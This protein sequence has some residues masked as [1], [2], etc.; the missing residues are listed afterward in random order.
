M[1]NLQFGARNA[2]LISSLV[3][4]SATGV[5]EARQSHAPPFLQGER[6]V[7]PP[8]ASTAPAQPIDVLHYGLDLVPEVTLRRIGGTATLLVAVVAPSAPLDSVILDAVKLEVFAVRVNGRDRGWSVPA[9]STTLSIEV[10]SAAPGD[11]LRQDGDLLTVAIDYVTV[12]QRGYRVFSTVAYTF[13][14]PEDARYWF[15]CVDA[16]RDKALFDGRFTVPDGFVVGSNGVLAGVETVPPLPNGA[17]RRWHW[18]ED[19]PIATYLICLQISRY[20]TLHDDADGIPLVYLMYPEDTL[21]ARV[22]FE[23]VPEMVRHFSTLFGPYPFEQYGMAA[24]E[25]FDFGGMEHQTMVTIVRSWVRG[26]RAQELGVA[27]ELSHM[28]F[29]DA[30]SPSQWNDMWLNEGFARYAEAL[31]L[32]H[33]DGIAAR[34]GR[35]S[36]ATVE[37]VSEDLMRR[38]PISNPPPEYLFGRTIYDK[39]AWVLHMLRREV[40]DERFFEILREHQERRRYGNSSI[41][42]F[43]ALAEEVSG[44][45]LDAFFDQWLDGVGYPILEYAA[46]SVP[47]DIAAGGGS[48]LLSVEMRQV[49]GT[50]GIPLLDV[51]VEIGVRTPSGERRFTV[52]SNQAMQTFEFALDEPALDVL[53]D[54]DGWLLKQVRRRSDLASAE[55]STAS[56]E[57]MYPNPAR[58]QASLELRIPY[59]GPLGTISGYADPTPVRVDVFDLRGRRV[60]T[61]LDDAL[62]PG[63]Y[64]VPFDGRDS[65]G[66][67]LAG[68]VYLIRVATPSGVETK[69]L[70]FVP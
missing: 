27:H 19:D 9:D 50:I 24:V 65:G 53:L 15:P 40:G 21:K 28:W 32:E 58:A 39:G 35:M 66:A 3:F 47:V 60:R 26:D 42:D 61:L 69:R 25:P 34:D 51:P 16:P 57:N 2:I 23:R 54:P 14:E 17:T 38:Y 6:K 59:T 45:P 12:P 63:R 43:R 4:A 68:G 49:Q 10:G 36:R 18:S 56:V 20:A 31:W 37:Y 7:A 29:G 41:A 5:A 70:A 8:A 30:V 33:V 67:Q 44:V 55:P 62:G 52:R 64:T 11:T 22:D 46:T 13:N 48:Y 1:A